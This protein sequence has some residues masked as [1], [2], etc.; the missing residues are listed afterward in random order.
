[1]EGARRAVNAGKVLLVEEIENVGSLVML[2]RRAERDR[3][4]RQIQSGHIPP[5]VAAF[6]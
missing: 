3:R 6:G 5:L 1:V 2:V 4:E